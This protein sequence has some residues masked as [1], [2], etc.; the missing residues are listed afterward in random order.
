MQ[1]MHQI[2]SRFPIPL[3]VALLQSPL[4]LVFLFLCRF[5]FLF[6]IVFRIVFRIFVRIFVRILVCFLLLSL[7][8][9]VSVAHKFRIVLSPDIL[10]KPSDQQ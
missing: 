7:L 6:R 3:C 5:L 1:N 4:R 8:R 10:S 2:I 9:S